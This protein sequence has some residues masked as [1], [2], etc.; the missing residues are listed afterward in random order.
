MYCKKNEEYIDYESCEDCVKDNPKEEDCKYYQEKKEKNEK[1]RKF[2]NSKFIKKVHNGLSS[3]LKIP[4]DELSTIL[5]TFDNKICTVSI[6]YLQELVKDQIEIMCDRYLNLKIKSQLEELF[7]KGLLDKIT[8][9]QENDK[10]IVTSIQEKLLQKTADFFN[11]KQNYSNKIVEQELDNLISKTINDKCEEA[12]Q[13]LK[14][15]TIDKFNK[16]AMKVMMKGMAK[17]LGTDK[18]LMK[19]LTS[20]DFE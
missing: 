7:K 18:R 6:N 2:K 16:E 4:E 14:K 12:L 3:I 5:N 20:G 17:Q 15:E 1:I 8:V 10:M 11:K 19:I 13:E 9:L